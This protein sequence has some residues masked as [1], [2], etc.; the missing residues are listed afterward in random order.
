MPADSDESVSA[1]TTNGGFDVIAY[2]H[3]DTSRIEDYA[4]H[5]LSYIYYSFAHL[6]GAEL[7]L[8]EDQ[9]EHIRRLVALK[10]T[11][12][13]LKI[14]LAFGGWG[15]CP[16]CSDV[17]A[18][19]SQRARFAESAWKLLDV[20]D[21]DG[22]DLDW[23][24][25]AVEGFPGHR[26]RPEDKGNFSLLVHALRERFGDRYELSF[27]AGG[28]LPILTES[29]D[30]DA[31]MPYVDRVNLMSYDLFN[32]NSTSTGHHTPLRSNDNQPDSVEAAV[33]FLIDRGVERHKIVIGAAAYARV[34]ETVEASDGPLHMDAVFRESVNFRDFDSYFDDR[35]IEYWDDSA[36]APYS[37]DAARRLFASYDSARSVA[38]KTRYSIEN[39]LGGIM[40]W[41]LGGDLGEQGL[42]Q[43][44]TDARLAAG[45]EMHR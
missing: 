2:L 9:V 8:D 32:G 12:P 7:A 10:T 17:F 3:G 24:Y 35:F 34:W 28:T 30:W 20:H 5:Q 36:Q 4:V 19:H 1:V 42:L 31:V 11:H 29:V 27:A 39:D 14:V 22:L 26:Y 40:F 38:L 15:G 41:Q 6:D 45:E 21:L 25:P 23:E 43:A 33:E 13:D 37:Y 16:T 18:V 44:I